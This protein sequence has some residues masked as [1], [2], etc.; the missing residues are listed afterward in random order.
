VCCKFAHLSEAEDATKKRDFGIN[1]NM[2]AVNPGLSG[3][4]KEFWK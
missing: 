3:L 4:F 1:Y 2:G